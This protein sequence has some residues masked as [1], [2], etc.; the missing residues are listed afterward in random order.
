MIRRPPRSTRTDTLFPYTTLFRSIDEDR[1]GSRGRNVITRLE[2][3]GEFLL[4]LEQVRRDF[5]HLVGRLGRRFRRCLGFLVGG[6]DQVVKG[7]VSRR[8]GVLERLELAV[9]LGDLGC[10]LGRNP[11]VSADPTKATRSEERRVGKE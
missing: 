9:E 6:A 10:N 4:D 5:R 1:A 8:T 2:A 7:L 3:V 11:T